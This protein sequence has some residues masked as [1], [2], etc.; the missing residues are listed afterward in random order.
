MKEDTNELTFCLVNIDSGIEDKLP[1][2]DIVP[3]EVAKRFKD[4]ICK[5]NNK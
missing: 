4:Y 2:P 5:S 1:R 3:Q